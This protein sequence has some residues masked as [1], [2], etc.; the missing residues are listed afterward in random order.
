MSTQMNPDQLKSFFRAHKIQLVLQRS[1]SYPVD[2]T[3][4]T[5]VQVAADTANDF[6]SQ[7]PNGKAQMYHCDT[8]KPIEFQV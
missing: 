1:E 3:Y 2:N 4:W 5:G 8:G 7:Y 6:L